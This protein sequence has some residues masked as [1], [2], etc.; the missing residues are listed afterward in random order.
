MKLSRLDDS[1]TDGQVDNGYWNGTGN[2]LE[3]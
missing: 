1:N 3:R 2:P